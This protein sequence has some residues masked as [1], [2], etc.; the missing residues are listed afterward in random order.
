MNFVTLQVKCDACLIG[1][2]SNVSLATACMNCVPPMYSDIS[3][4]AT[5]C[6]LCGAGSESV[7]RGND[8]AGG[9]K[10][11]LCMPGSYR[12]TIHQQ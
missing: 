2:F 7:Q 6:V 1:S 12:Y 5:T 4:G 3:A 10:C 9:F 11:S 8:E